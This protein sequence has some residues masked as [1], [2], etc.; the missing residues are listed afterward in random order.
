MTEKFDFETV[1]RRWVQ[2][3][4]PPAKEFEVLK[5]AAEEPEGAARLPKRSGPPLKVFIVGSPRSGTSILFFAVN[6]VLEL[7]GF[8]ESHVM[9][10]FQKIVHDF[11][12]S[13]EKFSDAKEGILVKCLKQEDFEP[14]IFDFIRS[15]YVSAHRCQSWVDK[16]PTDEAIHGLSLIETI[17]SDAKILATK[18][19][20][21]EVVSSYLKKF[22]ASFNDACTVW[23]NAMEGIRM[24]RGVCKNVLEVEHYEMANDPYN[25][26]Q[27]IATHLGRAEYAERMGRF[28]ALEK[29]EKTSV[30]DPRQR[31]TLADVEWSQQQKDYFV[32]CC[33]KTMD[34]FG[35]PM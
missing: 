32:R 3:R 13:I 24:A 20:G 19:T 23:V 9:P 18:R 29:V 10:V 2:L 6:C 8:G 12:T 28:L 16:T 35:Y 17:F 7:P 1:S 30:H 15:F 4:R 26:A 33:G 31:L 14:V 27:K 22:N 34:A 25:T 11:R 5:H 21:V